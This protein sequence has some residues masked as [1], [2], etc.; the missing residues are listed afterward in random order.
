MFDISRRLWPLFLVAGLAAQ[1][2][3]D[4][5]QQSRN[6]DFSNSGAT[7]PMR[8]GDTLPVQCAQGEMFFKTD[9]PAGSNLYGCS[10]ANVWTLQGGAEAG[11]EL[12]FKW[13]QSSTTQAQLSPGIFRFGKLVTRLPA[14]ATVQLSGSASGGLW[15]YAV[16]AGSV[17]VGHNLGGG[18]VA[19]SGGGFVTNDSVNGFP[20]GVLPLYQCVVSSGLIVGACDDLRSSLGAEVIKAGGSGLLEVDCE[21]G[22]GCLVDMAADLLPTRAGAND[23]TGLNTFTRLRAPQGGALPGS[24]CD[25]LGE[26]G[27]LFVKTDDPSGAQFYVCEGASGWKR[28]RGQPTVGVWL[29]FGW[30]WQS[31]TGVALGT[32]VRVYQMTLPAA[33]EVNRV[34]FSVVTPCAG[35]CGL[36]VA[37]YSADAAGGCAS[38]IAKTVTATDLG[39][40]G[41]GTV[42]FPAPVTLETGSYWLAVVT[43]GAALEIAAMGGG[44]MAARLLNATGPR[45]G[46][47]DQTIQGSGATLD[48]AS[49]GSCGSVTAS[50]SIYP[51][52]MLER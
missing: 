31:E 33:I 52:L 1:T 24:E 22:D 5:R 21:T 34:A 16:P 15:I 39:T 32:A 42:A 6:V 36:R 51:A 10:S 35:S 25:E 44:D 17:V 40:P 49:G 41:V 27:K 12:S 19:V 30:P 45:A 38:Q 37:V 20:T 26:A 13:T 2:K 46:T 18:A 50:S 3:V 43:D 8:T 7:L 29:P 11:A 28:Q 48:F 23:F 47:S 9:A 14:G 4:L